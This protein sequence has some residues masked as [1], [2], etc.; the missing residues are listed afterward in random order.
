MGELF[1]ALEAWGVA[2]FLRRSIWAYPIVNLTH[3][4]AIGTLVA[5]AVLMDIRV[6]GLT[7]RFTVDE[8]VG[9]LRPVAVGALTVAVAA[10]FLLFSVQATHYAGNAVFRTKMVLLALAILN[11][12]LFAGFRAHRDPES[13]RTRAMAAL[14]IALWLSV[15]LSGRLIAFFD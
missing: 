8:V 4:L 11:A 13:G 15:A 9:Y 1:Q 6:L 10:G 3:V 14:S 2:E 5:S 7:R 12:L